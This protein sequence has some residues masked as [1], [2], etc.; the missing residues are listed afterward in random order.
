VHSKVD[1]NREFSYT[2]PSL[3]YGQPASLTTVVHFLQQAS[4]C[5]L[6]Y[7]S[8]FYKAQSNWEFVP[9]CK[10]SKLYNQDWYLD[11]S[12]SRDCIHRCYSNAASWKWQSISM[13][14][15]LS[16]TPNQPTFYHS[17][18][19]FTFLIWLLC[20]LTS[21]QKIKL[22]VL[23]YPNSVYYIETWHTQLERSSTH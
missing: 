15:V 22:L 7:R 19:I 21:I 16:L 13:L 12:V 6:F 20:H 14:S 1:K 23:G 17:L 3:Y 18:S 10:A 9:V 11:K 2:F 5:S 4:I 8:L